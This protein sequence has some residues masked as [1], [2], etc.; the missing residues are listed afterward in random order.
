MRRL[1]DAIGTYVSIPYVAAA[2]AYLVL[3]V[4]VAGW[5]YHWIVH[6]TLGLLTSTKGFVVLRNSAGW[7]QEAV[8]ARSCMAISILA[9][10]V[11]AAVVC[12]A[13]GFTKL[14]GADVAGLWGSFMIS[15]SWVNILI[16]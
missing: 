16:Q 9:V 15:C 12:S 10:V 1:A 4:N 8:E 3:E 6:S 5:G 11:E 7:L 13:K 2:G 14:P